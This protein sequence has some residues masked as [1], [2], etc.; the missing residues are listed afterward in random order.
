MLIAMDQP[1]IMCRITSKYPN[2]TFN[3]VFPAPHISFI[4]VQNPNVLEKEL[5]DIRISSQNH[6][7]T[8]H[9]VLSHE[10]KTLGKISNFEII[11]AKTWNY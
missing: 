4:T 6:I 10:E 3:A 8:E 2:G 5:P 11:Y 1:C 7:Y 9:G